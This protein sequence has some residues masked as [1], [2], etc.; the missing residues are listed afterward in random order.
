[1]S[2]DI[3]YSISTAWDEKE[4]THPDASHAWL[5]SGSFKPSTTNLRMFYSAI[6]TGMKFCP[7]AFKPGTRREDTFISSDLLVLAVMN[8]IPCR[9]CSP[10]T[11][12]STSPR[13]R[14]GSSESEAS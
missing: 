4:P 1:M 10:R 6:A 5:W 3:T 8:H 7:C 2:R 14:R 12:P 11:H 9:C 13:V